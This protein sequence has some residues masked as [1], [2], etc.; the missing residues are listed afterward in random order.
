VSLSKI[1]SSIPRNSS[2]ESAPC[3]LNKMTLTHELSWIQLSRVEQ[4]NNCRRFES[5]QNKGADCL[6]NNIHKCKFRTIRHWHWK[7]IA[8]ERW[9]L[10]RKTDCAVTR[11]FRDDKIG[12]F[13]FHHFFSSLPLFA[14]NYF[15]GSLSFNGDQF[16]TTTLGK[17]T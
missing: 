2:V 17:S 14:L 12:T 7:M 11:I 10:W 5:N 13:C 8:G 3:R 6:S 9:K 15:S 1:T 16:K 4:L